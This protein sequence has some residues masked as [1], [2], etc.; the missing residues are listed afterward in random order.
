ME[1]H[2]RIPLCLKIITIWIK[3]S[4]WILQLICIL[5]TCIL[6]LP[7]LILPLPPLL[8]CILLLPAYLFPILLPHT[9]PF[10]GGRSGMAGVAFAIP[11]ILLICNAIPLLA[12][13]IQD[14][15]N[16]ECI[17]APPRL[18]CCDPILRK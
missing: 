3:I 1:T 17:S 12:H 13:A 14:N 8:T 2:Y 11:L 4:S 10:K 7:D 6:L 18:T 15:I 5:N 9:F 16:G